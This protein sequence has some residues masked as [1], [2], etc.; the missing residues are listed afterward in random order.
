MRS[1]CVGADD[2]NMIDELLRG[3]RVALISG[4]SRGLGRALA[5]ELAARGMRLAVCARQE[6]A[7]QEVASELR[8]AGGEVL[9]IAADLRVPR[10]I[11]RVCALTLDRLGP[12]EVLVNNASEL[13]PTPLPYLADLS[14]EALIDV[15]DV[16]LMAPFR[17]TRALIGGMLLRRRG[18]IVNISSDAAQHGYP[19]W[20]AYAAS[21]A[22]LEGLT[23]TWAAELEASGVRMVVVDPGD[24][25]TA[26]HRAALPDADP[27][28][29]RTPQQGARAVLEAASV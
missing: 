1:G 29:L 21:K 8:R 24:M 4:A 12:V 7:L 11:E 20:G 3:G 15:F 13:G 10:D 6:Q 17:L 28:S 5:V 23:R 18:L 19:G 14:A 2:G 26:M 25:D 22:A 9:A 16:N 27:A